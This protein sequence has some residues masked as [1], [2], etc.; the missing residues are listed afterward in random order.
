MR[1]MANLSGAGYVTRMMREEDWDADPAAI[2][3]RNV[4]DGVEVFEVYGAFF[5][6]AAAKFRDAVTQIDRTPKVLILRMRDVFAIDATGIRAL[7][8]IMDLASGDGTTVLLSGVHTQPL[9]ALDRAGVLERL[10][11][12][13]M[14][15]NIDA[16][17]GRAREILGAGAGEIEPPRA[18][19][20]GI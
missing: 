1:R 5:F 2:A 13:N 11:T 15:A 16:A 7:E 8:D 3:H 14:L 12:E 17:L 9:A 20:D 19:E 10:P 18:N 4:P 6:G